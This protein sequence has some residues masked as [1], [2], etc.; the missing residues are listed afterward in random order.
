MIKKGT[1]QPIDLEKR[2]KWW[3]KVVPIFTKGEYPDGRKVS[4]QGCLPYEV[5]YVRRSGRQG[6]RHE[7]DQV[8][9]RR[10]DR[11]QRGHAG[12]PAGQGRRR[13][14]AGP[15][16]STR[17]SR[18]RP[19]SYR[20]PSI[21]IMDAAMAIEARGDIKYGDKGDMTKAEIDKTIE[22]LIKAKKDGQFRAFW[23]TFDESVNLMASGETVVQSMWSPAVTAVRSRGIP[24]YYAPLK[25]GYRAWASCLGLMSHLKGPKLDA[26][27]EYLNWYMSGW[28][29]AFIAKQ[30]YYSSVLETVKKTMTADEWGYWYEGKPAKGEIKDPYGNLMEK[31]GR[32]ARRRRVL[33]SHGQR[34]LLEHADGG[35]RLPDQAL[36]RVPGGV[37]SQT[38]G[39]CERVPPVRISDSSASTSERL[40]HQALAH[41][42]LLPAGCPAP[43]GAARVLRHSAADDRRASAS[44][45]Y[46]GISSVPAFQFGNYADLFSLADHADA[47]PQD[48]LLRADRL[49]DHAGGRLHGRRISWSSTSAAS[50][51]RWRCSCCARCR[52]GPR[53]SSA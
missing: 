8:G 23:K 17:S 35:E 10:P 46:D 44:S 14:R 47:V 52:S 42:G 25:E 26:G 40:G 51:G 31:A 50:C 13:S 24:C 12:H 43:A 19:R 3:D 20:C 28:Q 48:R 15:S 45:S 41:R 9:D 36:E 38:A 6:L 33:D 21:G 32:G 30:G 2:F 27:Y 49:G 18:A 39:G 29:G 34:R 5:Q 53:T 16:C 11:V 22:I 1:L 4:T 7:A 37:M